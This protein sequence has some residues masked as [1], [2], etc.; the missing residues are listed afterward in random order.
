MQDTITRAEIDAQ[1][2]NFHADLHRYFVETDAGG[3]Y[4]LVAITEAGL[5]VESWTGKALARVIQT[6]TVV[7]SHGLVR[8]RLY[9]ARDT[10]DAAGTLAFDGVEVG[11]KAQIAFFQKA[12]V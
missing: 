11:G 4:D 3:R 8:A 5:I 10:G 12:G 6:G 2:G 7:N 9:I 1:R